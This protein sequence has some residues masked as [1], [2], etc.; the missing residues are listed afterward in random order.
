M[1]PKADSLEEQR[2][3][4]GGVPPTALITG[5]SSGIG[6]ELAKCFARNGHALVLVARSVSVLETLAD[7]LKSDHGVSVMVIAKDLAKPNTPEEIYRELGAAG[8]EID[9][10]VNNAGFGHYGLFRETS[11]SEELDMVQVNIVALTHLTKLLLPRMVERRRGRILNVASTAAFQPGPMMAVYYAS[12]AYVLSFSEA[13]REELRGT[14]V[15]VTALCPGPTRTAFQKNAGIERIRLVQW[16]SMD[17]RQVALL[18][19]HGLMQG[20]RLVVPGLFNK[21]TVLGVRLA[22]RA[23]ASWMVRQVQVMTKG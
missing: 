5:A 15:T 17:A 14:G 22:P 12:K 16:T 10:L 3:T 20:K 21:L 2:L 8:V 6:Y 4:E 1:P 7:E 13:I 19:Y 23:L 11:L 18:G 9:I